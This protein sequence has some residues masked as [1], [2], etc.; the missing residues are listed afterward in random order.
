[1]ADVDLRFDADRIDTIEA[2]MDLRRP[3]REAIEEVA[4]VLDGAPEEALFVLDM[5][6]GVGKTYAAA[7]LIEYLYGAGVRN[8]VIVTPGTAVQ[9]KTVGNF[10]PGHRKYVKGMASNPAVITIDDAGR[11]VIA[12]DLADENRLKIFVV[13]VQSLLRPNTESSRRAYNPHE[14]VGIGLYQ[15]LQG[16]DDVVVVADEYHVYSSV[17]A[18]KFAAAL[19][20]LHPLAT[21]GVTATPDPSTPSDQI[22]Y[23][24][25]LADAIAD[26]YV[27]IPVLVARSDGVADL[28]TQ[29]ADGIA[30]LER[31]RIAVLEYARRTKKPPI[32]PVMLV[33][34]QSIQDAIEIADIL[35]EPTML[36]SAGAVLTVTSDQPDATLAR[37]EELDAPGN[38][39]RAVVSVNMLRE[40]WDCKAVYVIA[41]VRA[42]ES[43]LLTEQIL[44]RGLRLPFGTRTGVQ[45]LDT[46]EVLS[47]HKFRDLLKSAGVLL[48]QTLGKRSEGAAMVADPVSGVCRSPVALSQG[49]TDSPVTASREV[50]LAVPTG[51]RAD[52]NQ[53]GL[54]EQMDDG[55]VSANSAPAGYGAGLV[56]SDFT[57]RLAQADEAISAVATPIQPQALPGVR[58]PLFLPQVTSELRRDPFSLNSIDLIA[59]KALGQLFAEDQGV[60]LVRKALDVARTTTGVTLDI[61]DAEELVS[62]SLPLFGASSITSDLVS[63]LLASDGVE[64]S[65]E[66]M[67]A[68]TKIAQAFLAG[69]GVSDETPWR[70]EHGQ[71]ATMKLVSWINEQR[72]NTP[73]QRVQQVRQVEWPDPP[74]R[75]GGQPPADRHVI[76]DRTQFERGYPYRGWARSIY[77]V[78]RFDAY[79][80]EFRLAELL[81]STTGVQAWVRIDNLV[82]L[83]IGYQQGTLTR[84]YIPDFLVIDDDGVHW[85]VEGKSDKDALEPTVLAKKQAAKSWVI[86]VNADRDVHTRWAY[87]FLT[88]EKIKLAD[89]WASLKVLGGPV[90]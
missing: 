2:A 35:A 13:T 8:I 63:R 43:Q 89:S 3:N 62:A 18:K 71:A 76:T 26:G 4:K 39:F 36:G 55:E 28:R 72:S 6:T 9:A 66:E 82:P 90:T 56:I 32:E 87:L 75:P 85:I 88:E 67:E 31:K 21:I 52:P 23:A 46:V 47:H 80:T 29:L 19:H 68:A 14:S 53:I 61:S 17:S 15:Y 48:H 50:L 44:G 45:M 65:V 70:R 41:A 40:G 10:T 58:I 79:S 69:A 11:G 83:H 16:R 77:D 74:E 57:D 81:E 54:L 73:I 84:T 86:T 5:A 51:P 7:G 38:A 22:I 78:V 42:M 27:K 1:V 12:N 49:G 25:P 34:A 64:A 30:L 60:A 37:V 59:V 20:E 24:Y 33:V